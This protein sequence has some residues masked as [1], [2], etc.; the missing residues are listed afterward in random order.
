MAADNMLS[1]DDISHMSLD[2]YHY[3]LLRQEYEE[4]YPGEAGTINVLE[5]F[6]G[7]KILISPTQQQGISFLRSAVSS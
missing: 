1:L 3:D 6:F 4:L 2:K 5:D 7:L